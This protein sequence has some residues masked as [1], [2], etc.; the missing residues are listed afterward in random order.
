VRVVVDTGPLYAAADEDDDDHERCI[1]VLVS[2]GAQ[3]IIPALVVAEATYLVGTRLGSVAEARFLRGLEPFEVEAPLTEEWRR[4]A[5]LVE[6]YGDSSLG[7]TDASVVTLAERV[8]STIVIT[9]DRRHFGAVRPRHCR[10]LH[11]LP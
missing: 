9:L 1:D 4:I 5:E 2:H 7:G 6:K 8:K 3:L 11:I 10:T